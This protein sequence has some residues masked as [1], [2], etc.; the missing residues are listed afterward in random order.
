MGDGLVE[1]IV[2]FFCEEPVLPKWTLTIF[3]AWVKGRQDRI[4]KAAFVSI[5]DVDDGM[6]LVEEGR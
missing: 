1:L 5:L 2:T 3:G 4:S 6:F